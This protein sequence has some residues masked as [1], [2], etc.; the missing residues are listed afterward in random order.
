M[1]ELKDAKK[2]YDE[3]EIPK[4]LSERIQN[5]IDQSGGKHMKAEK[6]VQ[7]NGKRKGFRNGMIAA[8]A[9]LA[10]FTAGVNTNTAFAKSVSEIPV[11]GAVARVL[12]FT[13]Y[14]KTDELN[15]LKISVEVPSVEMVSEN[16][17]GLAE[18]VNEE[19]Q[20]QC[21]KYA[22]EAIERAKEYR[23]AF[24]ETGG[25]EEEWEAHNIEIK[26]SYEVKNQTEDYLSFAV[27]GTENWSSAYSETRYYNI[28]LKSEKI[29]TLKDLLGDNYIEVANES[30]L[31]QI[32]AK[33]KETGLE[34]FDEE[35]GGFT[36][37]SDTTKFYVNEAGNPV[38]VFDKYEIAP[39][40]AGAVEFEI[41]K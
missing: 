8:A 10:V 13:S 16:T 20:A 32:E 9:A 33:E 28:D 34:F 27:T 39:G 22:D 36:T 17:N 12:T 31:S 40:A 3:I 21:Q 37:V 38:I 15:D 4:E 35:E 30:I 7:M 18:S 29:V 11:I 19:I 41:Q 25:T 1:S 26:V 23:A 24:M 6:I 14:E 2:K 5:A